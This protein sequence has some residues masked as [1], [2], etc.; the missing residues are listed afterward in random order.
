MSN[1][2]HCA[3][4]SAVSRANEWQKNRLDEED[5][6]GA[7]GHRKVSPHFALRLGFPLPT[8]C[9]KDGSRVW[10]FPILR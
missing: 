6:N 1:H 9:S 7:L 8:G 5:Y 3:R 2:C 4:H 10:S